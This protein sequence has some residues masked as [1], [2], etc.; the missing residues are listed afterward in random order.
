MR[1]AKICFFA[2]VLSVSFLVA[3]NVKADLVQYGNGAAA[4]DAGLVELFT[5]RISGNAGSPGGSSSDVTVSLA[6]NGVNNN[7]SDGTLILGAGS[8]TTGTFTGWNFT[9]DFGGLFAAYESWGLQG[10]T[11]SDVRAGTHNPSSTS[12]LRNIAVNENGG[13]FQA[14]TGQYYNKPAFGSATITF[15]DRDFSFTVTYY[16]FANL[17]VV[18]PP[19]G[20]VPE[21]ATLALMGLGLAGLGVV[22][23]RMKGSNINMSKNSQNVKIDK[24][25]GGSLVSLVLAVSFLIAA[26]AKAD[27]IRSVDTSFLG[28]DYKLVEIFTF[29]YDGTAVGNG[30]NATWKIAYGEG[31]SVLTGFG[32]DQTTSTLRGGGVQSLLATWFDSSPYGGYVGEWSEDSSMLTV[33]GEAVSGFGNWFSNLRFDYG[34]EADELEVNFG[35]IPQYV[36]TLYAVQPAHTPEPA[37]MAV[38]GFGLA[39]LGLTR[40]RRRR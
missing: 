34:L 18:E 39:G 38:I 8:Q 7:T 30:A 14:W 20:D 36:F 5:V 11:L 12:D 26:P 28:D 21:P 32:Y 24:W 29:T 25:G 4:Q 9:L 16:G 37:T 6:K 15:Y 40:I 22:R 17:P 10:Y 1:I 13:S 3:A 2:L 33:N 31:F 23:R 19:G 27:V 35:F